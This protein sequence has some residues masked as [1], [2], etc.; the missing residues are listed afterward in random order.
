M[1]GLV[2]DCGVL[3][4]PAFPGVLWV[5]PKVAMKSRFTPLCLEV[6]L[7]VWQVAIDT[8]VAISDSDRCRLESLGFDAVGG[9]SSALVLR[10][11]VSSVY[12]MSLHV[13]L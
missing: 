10:D 6:L 4:L 12:Y 9:Q 2:V 5:L 11:R 13:Q 1:P 7:Q 3:C 8:K